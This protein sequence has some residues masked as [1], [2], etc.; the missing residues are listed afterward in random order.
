MKETS[1]F[2]MEPKVDFCFKELLRDPLV[3]QGF[4]AAVLEVPPEEIVRTE[5]LPTYLWKK[6]KKEKQGILDVRV[7]IN[8]MDEMDVEIQVE[9]FREWPERSVFY[10]GRMFT[11]NLREGE[12]YGKL[13]KCIHVGILDFILFPEDKEYYSRFHI[14]EDRRRRKYTDKLEVHIIELPKLVRRNYPDSELLNWARFLNGKGKEEL[15]MIGKVN[16]YLGRA[17]E[18]LLEISG[19]ERKRL[20]YEAR[21]KATL[22]HNYLMRTN[23]EEGYREG[24]ASGYQEGHTSGVTEGLALAKNML[25]LSSEGKSAQEIAKELG[26]SPEEVR[27]IIE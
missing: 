20:A 19:S 23:R 10:L 18:V 16:R 7:L 14:W 15:Q 11:E 26:V 8:G 1:S 22:D 6:R 24:H 13:R 17:Y 4:I 2:I 5:L 27:K 3:R 21:K 25:R 12:D 9:A